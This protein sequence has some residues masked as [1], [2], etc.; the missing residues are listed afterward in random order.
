MRPAHDK[1]RLFATWLALGFVLGVGRVEIAA[2]SP[3]SHA[4]PSAR[5]P[6]IVWVSRTGAIR[7][8]SELAAAR[9][10]AHRAADRTTRPERGNARDAHGPAAPEPIVVE[11]TG[12][13]HQLLPK[14][15]DDGIA[16]A[17]L[18][19]RPSIDGMSS[20]IAAHAARHAAHAALFHDA[21]APPPRA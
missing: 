21:N 4:N 17:P 3:S 16:V 11:G 15:P 13:D 18:Q 7:P 9:P 19:G 5:G 2:A 20:L 12:K 6:H 10:P 1:R 14:L 8:K